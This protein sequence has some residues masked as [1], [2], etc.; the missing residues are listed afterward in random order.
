MTQIERE[1]LVERYLGGE[2]NQAQESDF[3]LNVAVDDELQR[4]LKAFRIMDQTIVKDR[5][6][7]VPERSRY[8]ENIMAMLATTQVVAG[9]GAAASVGA[10]SGSAGSSV[11]ASSSTSIPAAAGASGTAAGASAGT[12]GVLGAMGLGAWKLAAIAV[13]GTML[14]IGTVM[15]VSPG[16]SK[17]AEDRAVPPVTAPATPGLQQDNAPSQPDAVTGAPAAGETAAPAD[18]E[19]K[20]DAPAVRSDVE[21]PHGARS[22]RSTANRST[23]AAQVDE[24]AMRG[25]SVRK[26]V[27]NPP[28]RLEPTTNTPEVKFEVDD[29]SGTKPNK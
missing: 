25:T 27:T 24:A 18:V 17:K 5:E 10:S 14:T 6:L 26:P 21:A 12:G 7:V 19:T 23:G 13:V 22:A 20:S 4:T 16:D 11:A 9:G 1:E 8:R 29:K 2:M 15:V 3:F 28:I